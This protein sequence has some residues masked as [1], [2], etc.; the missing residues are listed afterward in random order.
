L[1]QADAT[2]CGGDEP[3]SPLPMLCEA[4][5]NLDFFIAYASCDARSIAR[6]IRTYVPQRQMFGLM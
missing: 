2:G 3:I 4:G 5:S 1:L 6:T